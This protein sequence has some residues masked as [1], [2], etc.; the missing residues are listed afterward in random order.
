MIL[1]VIQ[2]ALRAQ[3]HPV[4]TGAQGL[5][6]AIGVAATDLTPGGTVFVH[7]ERWTA[8]STRPV[9]QGEKVRILRVEGL[10]LLV[11]KL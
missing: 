2:R 3:R 6:G 9:Q 8:S 11:D 1:F 5:V 7:G 4:A 10:A